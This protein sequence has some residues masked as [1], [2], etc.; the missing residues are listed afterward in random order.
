MAATEDDPFGN[1][2]FHVEIGNASE[3]KAVF[4]EVS[5]LKGDVEEYLKRH[6]FIRR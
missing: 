1:F 6:G 5:G 2:N 4:N 3:L